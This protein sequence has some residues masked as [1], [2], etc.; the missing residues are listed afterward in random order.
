MFFC[1]FV[2]YLV[3]KWWDMN[4]LCMFPLEI[5]EPEEQGNVVV[6]VQITCCIIL[7]CSNLRPLLLTTGRVCFWNNGTCIWVS[8]ISALIHSLKALEKQKNVIVH[9][10]LRKLTKATVKPTLHPEL[11]LMSYLP[12]TLKLSLQLQYQ[13]NIRA[14]FASGVFFCVVTDLWPVASWLGSAVNLLDRILPGVWVLS[15]HQHWL[16]TA[17]KPCRESSRH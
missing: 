15:G 4:D 12:T 13:A 9:R 6:N 1:H 11:R 16:K 14:A 3:W 7:T 2:P 17:H 8:I 10:G 5:S